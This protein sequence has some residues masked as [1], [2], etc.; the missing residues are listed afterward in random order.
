MKCNYTEVLRLRL[1]LANE[2][3]F[4]QNYKIIKYYPEKRWLRKEEILVF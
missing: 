2:N 4:E 3:E 1:F